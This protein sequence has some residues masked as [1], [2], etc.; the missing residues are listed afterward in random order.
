M[1]KRNLNTA[2]HKKILES[3][4]HQIFR[5]LSLCFR[6]E[7]LHLVFLVVRLIP[8]KYYKTY[9]SFRVK[10]KKS[11]FQV[12]MEWDARECQRAVGCV[13]DIGKKT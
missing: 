7:N 12:Y 3:D 5:M 11:R 8:L 10:K 1:H 13:I 6:T 4:R 2:L 9:L